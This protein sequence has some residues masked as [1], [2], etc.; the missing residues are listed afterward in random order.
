M[1]VLLARQTSGEW[2]KVDTLPSGTTGSGIS[3]Y[4]V[5]KDLGKASA[6][7][8]V[9]EIDK[10][11]YRVRS[12]PFKIKPLSGHYNDDENS[13][14]SKGDEHER[15]G[16]NPSSWGGSNNDP[17]NYDPSYQSPGYTNPSSDPDYTTHSDDDSWSKHYGKT[18]YLRLITPTSKTV[19]DADSYQSVTWA[20]DGSCKKSYSG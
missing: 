18:N 17:D 7:M 19:W 5:R 2:K 10:V 9:L 15:H 14:Y 12:E 20:Y 11:H 1:V 3:N 6:Y 4:H 8:V 16:G 13:W